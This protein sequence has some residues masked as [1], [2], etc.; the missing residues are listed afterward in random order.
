MLFYSG[1]NKNYL[2]RIFQQGLTALHYAIKA[3]NWGLSKLLLESKDLN[4]NSKDHLLGRT[5][6]HAMIA[7]IHTD[8]TGKF[9][10]KE[11]W[12][13]FRN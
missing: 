6:L 9:Q 12:M 11:K 5:P 8:L 1:N 7:S 4:A 10:I 3:K 2:F 13:S